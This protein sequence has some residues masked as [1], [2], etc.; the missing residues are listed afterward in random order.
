MREFTQV[1]TFTNAVLYLELEEQEILRF[2]DL[3]V[4]EIRIVEQVKRLTHRILE[5][6]MA[7]TKSRNFSGE[8]DEWGRIVDEEMVKGSQ[9]MS[10][11]AFSKSSLISSRH[12]A[13]LELQFRIRT[14][15]TRKTS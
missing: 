3:C 8:G 4:D 10:A 15:R 12:N 13:E 14:L 6:Q 5:R 7:L 2:M 9:K 11:A 1:M